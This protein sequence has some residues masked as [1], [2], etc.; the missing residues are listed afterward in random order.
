MEEN[1]F[2]LKEHYFTDEE[3]AEMMSPE[4]AKKKE[5]E[6]QHK[7]RMLDIM[8]GEFGDNTDT[9]KLRYMVEHDEWYLPIA[10][11][12]DLEIINVKKG[13]FERLFAGKNKKTGKKTDR[14]GQ[15]GQL[16]PVYQS[17]AKIKG[18]CKKVNGRELANMLPENVS[19]LLVDWVED[20]TIRELSKENFEH[21]KALVG[22]VEV[23]R[24]LCVD[25]PVDTAKL[26]AARFLVAYYG[27]NPYVNYDLAY[28]A[29]HKDN[30]YFS[31]E[32]T[33]K[34]MTGAQIFQEILKRDYHAGLKIDLGSIYSATSVELKNVVL[35]R[36]F[37]SRA[38]TEDICHWR[39]PELVAR[40]RKEFELWLDFVQFPKEREI[41]E[42]SLN[43]KKLIYAVSKKEDDLWH[44]QET[45]NITYETPRI[46]KTEKFELLDLASSEDEI[47]PGPSKILCPGK[48][49]GRLFF[50]LPERD[51]RE[52]VWR[53]G[54]SLGFCRILSTADIAASK[55]RIVYINELIKLIPSG[56]SSIP[57]DSWLSYEGGNFFCFKKEPLQLDWLKQALAQAQ[58]NCSLI[59]F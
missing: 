29:T 41:F 48:L 20:D 30:D 33:V 3:I 14:E 39:A 53:P 54:F 58:K 36:N 27:D 18:K 12:G 17:E 7:Q 2:N 32:A 26:R 35:S 16:L 11:D 52:F 42:E 13:E 55:E 40:N 45:Y 43:G 4:L 37:M 25:G 59:A 38:L 21:L 6:R 50:S 19:G 22:A 56:E 9:Y 44:P 46:V 23:E 5:E 51:R 49:A 24:V 8:A 47:A 10:P 31:E 34:E 57:L 28:A 1:K 15:G